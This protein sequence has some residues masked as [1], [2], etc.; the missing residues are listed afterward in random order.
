MEN[1][2]SVPE[3]ITLEETLVLLSIALIRINCDLSNSFDHEFSD[4]FNYGTDRLKM[5]KWTSAWR[6]SFRHI[7]CS[8]LIHH[9]FMNGYPDIASRAQNFFKTHA[10]NV[11]NEAPLRG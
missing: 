4:V 11:L 2:Y 6:A 3:N 8:Q 10:R 9:L 7:P 5:Y 1:N